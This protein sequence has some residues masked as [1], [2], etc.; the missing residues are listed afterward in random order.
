MPEKHKRNF[1]KNKEAKSILN[2]AARKLKINMEEI[3]KDKANVKLIETG[4]A[5]I[6][7]I[8][9]KPLLAKT[10]EDLFPTLIFNEYFALAPK[11]IVD[12]GAVPYVCKGANVMK[13][14]IRRLDGEFKK[15]D[16]VF[17]VDERH[18]K[19]LAVGETLYD[20]GEAEKAVHGAVIRNVHFVGDKIWNFLK[21][22]SP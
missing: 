11:A 22:F 7:L 18:G 13:P 2:Q 3:L 1:L 4:F 12:M 15:G 16:F 17:V 10:G 14:G 8:N 20:K 9:D 21:E 6:Y 19:P 5:E